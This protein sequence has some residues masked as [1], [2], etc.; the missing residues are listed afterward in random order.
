MIIGSPGSTLGGGEIKYDKTC[1]S[2]S[3][4]L[5]IRNWSR[6]NPAVMSGWNPCSGG[7]VTWFL[8]RHD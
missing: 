2:K 4:L 6:I 8:K 5:V 1:T 7:G 3:R